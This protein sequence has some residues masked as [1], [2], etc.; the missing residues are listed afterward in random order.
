ME[1]INSSIDCFVKDM[2]NQG[3]TVADLD[4]F[5]YF[6]SQDL[7]M[8]TDREAECHIKVNYSFIYL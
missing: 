5:D 6:K 4:S 8:S 2:V 3:Q 1:A 7:D